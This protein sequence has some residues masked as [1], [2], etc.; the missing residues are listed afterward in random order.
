MHMFLGWGGLT[1]DME[2][3]LRLA[4]ECD[5]EDAR[6]LLSLFPE[7][8]PT[9]EEAKEVLNSQGE[10]A[11]ALYFAVSFCGSTV[12]EIDL[13]RRAALGGVARAQAWMAGETG[14]IEWAE[15][16]AAQG[17]REGLCLLAEHYWNGTGCAKD[18][19]RS[20]QLYKEA[21]DLGDP[22]G[23]WTYGHLAFNES[24]PERY[25]WWGRALANE[26]RWVEGHLASAALAQLKTFDTGASGRAVFE[27][28]A[29]CKGHVFGKL[30]EGHVRAVEQTV[31]LHDTW[32]A[33]AERA[34][35]CWIWVAQQK[36]VAK[37]I[38]NIISKI[39]W[40]MRAAW[41]EKSVTEKVGID[42][43]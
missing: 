26:G 4:R 19:T 31:A 5:H 29:A 13:L 17:D 42:A 28:G 23:Y 6:W 10:D 43:P 33:S 20:L 27:I 41:S 14:D 24:D 38:R 34:I 2:G 1:Q 11:T 16:A 22:T 15:K 35:Y 8:P 40:A 9:V 32:C 30:T 7:G 37:D 3:G 39:L 36:K 18:E 21:G 12:A 25:Y